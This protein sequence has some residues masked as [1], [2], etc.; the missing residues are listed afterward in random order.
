MCIVIDANVFGEVFN[1]N[2]ALH[3]EFKPVLDW[4]TK[5]GGCAVFG[6]TKYK[7]ELAGSPRYLGMFLQLK[8]AGRAVEIKQ[9]LVDAR[10]AEL[11]SSNHDSDCDDQHLIAILCV[12]GCML[13]CSQDK[14][15]YRH[16]RNRHN[17]KVR[18]SLGVR[19]PVKTLVTV[20]G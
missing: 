17:Y 5:K 13:V 2:S 9:D 16:I 10:E 11:I 19:Q 4:I 3:C 15:A 14:R 1:T 8:K 7:K 20:R 12:S 6:G 18:L